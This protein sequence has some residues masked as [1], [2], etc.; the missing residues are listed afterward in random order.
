MPRG[1]WV[2]PLRRLFQVPAVA[3]PIRWLVV[4]LTQ[5][6]VVSVDAKIFRQFLSENQ[7]QLYD[8]F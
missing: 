6:A 1:A 8:V 7:N 5:P 2:S 4:R 3:M